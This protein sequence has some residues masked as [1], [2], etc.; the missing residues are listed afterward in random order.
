MNQKKGDQEAGTLQKLADLQ[1]I[2]KSKS[3]ILKKILIIYCMI[4]GLNIDP[5]DET[6][7]SLE[8]ISFIQMN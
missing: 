5:E 8:R 2:E 4:P 6:P 3:C 7:K 1:H